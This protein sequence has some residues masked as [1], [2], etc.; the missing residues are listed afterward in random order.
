MA[1][2]AC[3][4]LSFLLWL[5]LIPVRN[6][7]AQQS[8]EAQR[9]APGT[10]LRGEAEPAIDGRYQLDAPALQSSS[11]RPPIWPPLV[12]VGVGGVGAVISGMVLFLGTPYVGPTH[13]SGEP[14]V[15]ELRCTVG[16]L[17]GLVASSGILAG[18]LVWLRRRTLERRRLS[19]MVQRMTGVG[20]QI[21]IRL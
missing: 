5:C 15:Q 17:M 6:A 8:A 10:F 4:V 19:R 9:P 12:L 7:S 3:L 21:H 1:F 14:T 16:G 18:G 11:K 20:L 13:S 2:R